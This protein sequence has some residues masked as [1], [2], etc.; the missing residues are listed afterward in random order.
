MKHTNPQH[1]FSLLEIL[2]AF[3]ILSL[4]LGILLKIFSGGVN[5]AG[6]AEQYTAAVQIGESLMTRAGIEFPLQASETTG[7]E[8]DLYNWQLLITP[9]NFNPELI[10]LKKLKLIAFKVNVIVS[11]D[12]G[13][14]NQRQ[15]ELSSIK[16]TMEKTEEELI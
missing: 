15:I 8:D 12:T 14:A 4:S 16:L 5:T 2:I 13:H 7:T 3:S 10:D 6:V 11:W 1:G 9:F